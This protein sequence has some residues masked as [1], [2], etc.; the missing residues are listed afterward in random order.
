MPNP[1]ELMRDRGREHVNVKP[2][3]SVVVAGKVHITLTF[4]V[5][6]VVVNESHGDIETPCFTFT[7]AM[8]IFSKHSTQLS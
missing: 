3:V 4:Y 2:G 8:L 5:S 1:S 6:L 7:H